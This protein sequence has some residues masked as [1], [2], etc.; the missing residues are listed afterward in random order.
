MLKDI[1][2]HT[3][4]PATDLERAKEFYKDK[5]ELD[6][7]GEG[8]GGVFFTTAGGTRFSLC[9]TPNPDRGGHTQLGF[10]VSD[11]ETEVAHLKTRGVVFEEYDLPGLKTESGIAQMGPNRGAWFKDT[12]GNT[13]GLVELNDE[14]LR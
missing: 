2:C 13:I 4:L 9:P 3:T 1:H 10:T 6:P 14:S 8:P 7:S 12:E 11:L 5:L